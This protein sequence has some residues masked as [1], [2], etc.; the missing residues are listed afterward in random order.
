MAHQP[1]RQTPALTIGRRTAGLRATQPFRPLPPPTGQPPYRLNLETVLGAERV[2]AITAAGRLALHIVGDTGGVKAPEPQQIVAMHMEDDF[3]SA[4]AATRPAFFFHL[5]DVVYYYGEASEYYGQF[6]EP[7]SHYPVPIIAI[8]GNHDGDIQ[9]PSVPSLAAFVE[10]FCAPTPQH[11]SE[12]GDTARETMTQPNVYFTLE[13]PFLTVIGLYTNVPEHG[14]LDDTQ[15]AWF[16]SELAAA[17]TDRALIV[18]MHHPIH[19]LDT[20]HGSSDYMG[21]ILDAAIRETGRTPDA[22]FAA[23]VHNYQRF[24]R[25]T[26]G[27]DIPYIVAGGGGYWNLHY[28]TKDYGYPIPLPLAVP[29]TDVTL[30]SYMDNRHG[31]MRLEVTPRSL[32]G[33]YYTVPRPQEPWGNPAVRLDSFTLDLRNHHLSSPTDA[34][35][36]PVPA[37]ST[38]GSTDASLTS[39]PSTPPVTPTGTTP[40]P[41]AKRPKGSR[42]KKSS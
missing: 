1:P 8:P 35:P 30:E 5:G 12:A 9:D 39:D 18:A 19:S 11:S 4:D 29:G 23:H 27:R 33:D 17:P 32:T 20:H 15:I 21:Q 22:V 7:Y 3:A 28:M 2:A 34:P 31:Y 10:N 40:E 14:R 41:S 26:G 16:H 38:Q 6:Y 25:S 42:R 24:T 13:A 36:A 37:P